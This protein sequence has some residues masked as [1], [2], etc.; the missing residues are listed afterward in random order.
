MD[1]LFLS[2]THL[3]KDMTAEEI[4]KSLDFMNGYEK[5]FTKSEI[6]LHA[7]DKTNSLC[8]VLSG[9]VNIKMNN[10]RGDSNIIGFAGQG[11]LFAEAYSVVRQKSLLCD[12]EAAADTTVLF[13]Q[14]DK[15]LFAD[16]YPG[17]FC[18]KLIKNM[19]MISAEKNLALSSR[20]THTAPRLIRDRLISYLSEQSAAA[21]GKTFKIP[22]SRQQLADY[23][24]VERSALS[25]ELSKM[26]RD[27]LIDYNKNNFC[28]Y[29]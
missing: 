16:R 10:S 7:G 9:G 15:L 28:L 29:F 11:Q 12:A 22:F 4:K 26:K 19:L 13:L 6:I 21:S 25:N 5:R 3:F 20:M 14:T 8:L 24:S 23:L 2:K 27:G 1:C 18:I 17:A